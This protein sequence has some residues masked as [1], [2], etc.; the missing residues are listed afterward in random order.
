MERSEQQSEGLRQRQ[1]PPVIHIMALVRYLQNGTQSFFRVDRTVPGSETVDSRSGASIGKI[2][3][4]IYSRSSEISALGQFI[5]KVQ[6]ELPA[7]TVKLLNHCRIE[8]AKSLNAQRPKSAA[9]YHRR[10]IEAI[11]STGLADDPLVVSYIHSLGQIFLNFGEHR[12]ALRF[13]Q[14]AHE[15]SIRVFGKTE[16]STIMIETDYALT[17]QLMSG[18]GDCA[19]L[20][21]VWEGVIHRMLGV[22]PRSNRG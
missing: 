22:K 20:L 9:K 16:M 11:K 7:C 5:V 10:I 19:S 3:R 15:I 14:D 1:F 13:L 21:K 6:G 4:H 2:A 18:D 8:G 12:L 17:R